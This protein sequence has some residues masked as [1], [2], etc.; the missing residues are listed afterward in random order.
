[1][2]YVNIQVTLSFPNQDKQQEN[3]QKKPTQNLAKKGWHGIFASLGAC[4][5]KSPSFTKPS[6]SI[7]RSRPRISS[8]EGKTLI[9]LQDC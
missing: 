4:K 9:F 7:C 1:M 6:R 2:S 3:H 8:S 5:S